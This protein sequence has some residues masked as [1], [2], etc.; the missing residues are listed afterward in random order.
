MTEH[1]QNGSKKWMLTVRIILILLG[2]IQ[3]GFMAWANFVS[4]EI[5][6]AK[7]EFAAQKAELSSQ[8]T[9]MTNIKDNICIIRSR[10]DTL[11]AMHLKGSK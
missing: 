10:L 4:N 1:L 3:V 7:V 6:N 2:I 9:D 5:L 8:K 11:I